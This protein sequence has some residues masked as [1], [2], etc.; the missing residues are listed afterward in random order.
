MA[1]KYADPDRA[2][3]QLRRDAGLRDAGF[4]VVH[5]SWAELT[6]APDQVI[7]AIKAA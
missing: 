5:I 2:R 7:R 6:V 4:E 1:L 3:Q